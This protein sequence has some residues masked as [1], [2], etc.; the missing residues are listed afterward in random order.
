MAR[1]Q[2]AAAVRGYADVGRAAAVAELGYR[3][4]AVAWWGVLTLS[5]AF[6]SS[7]ETKRKRWRRDKMREEITRS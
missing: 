7:M 4:A 3:N 1:R 2:G 6:L 5:T